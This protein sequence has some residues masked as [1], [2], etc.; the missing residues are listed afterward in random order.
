MN[1]AKT[2]ERAHR[3]E[4]GR[5][6]PI[7]DQ[8]RGYKIGWLRPDI[9]AAITVCAL[10]VPEAMAYASIA[11]VPPEAGLYAAPAAFILYAIFATSRH[12]VVA[13]S[14]TVALVSASVIAPLAA[15]GSSE[16]I[17]LTAGLAVIAGILMISAGVMRLGF[18]TDFFAKSVMDGFILGLGLVIGLGQLD[19]MLGLK[20]VGDNFF[21]EAWDLIRQIP[22]THLMTTA[23]GVGC[24]VIIIAFRRFLPKVPG[25]LVAVI[26]GIAVVAIFNL[27]LQDVHIVG[28][29]PAGV[30][31]F[32]IPDIGIGDIGLLIPGALAVLLVGYAESISTARMYAAKNG[33]K[34]DSNQEFIA[35]GA[36]NLGA[37]LSGGFVVDGS[38][39]KTAAAYELKPQTQ[40]SNLLVGG[41]MLITIVALTPLFHDLPEATLGAVVIAAIIHVVDFGKLKRLYQLNKI[42]LLFGLAALFGVLILGLLAGLLVA[43][44]VSF[45]ALVY[46]SSR[47]GS[48]VLGRE[49]GENVY[50]DISRHPEDETFPGLLI[51]RF[52][53]EL[54]FANSSYFHDELTRLISGSET[55]V[56]AVLVDAESMHGL[57][58]TAAEMLQELRNELSEA[59]IAV[60]MARVHGQVRDMMD[61]AGLTESIGV[62]HLFPSV[63]AGV[64]YYLDELVS[65]AAADPEAASEGSSTI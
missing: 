40:L 59:N 55:Q 23:V 2:V 10:T 57:D 24:L 21:L 26:A 45:V 52:D 28:D 47:P 51:F 46:R 9:L 64:A 11:G 39:S 12:L 34:V 62:E 25:A 58:I 14:T 38:L 33:Y 36:S 15:G 19:K 22:D 44:G 42:E 3:F 1:A 16:Y 18:I 60:L 31:P 32:G 53:A 50:Q 54:F 65:T 5:F 61:R 13:P 43:I 27:D 20:A 17:A 8:F 49:S 6:L 41:F 48:A 35:L 4:I 37:G 56:K 63:R 29:I 30:P 7:I